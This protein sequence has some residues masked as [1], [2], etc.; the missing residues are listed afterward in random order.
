MQWF[1][2]QWYKSIETWNKAWM[3]LMDV[4]S[5]IVV[6]LL[7]ATGTL[8]C[9]LFLFIPFLIGTLIRVCKWSYKYILE[10]LYFLILCIVGGFTGL[11]LGECLTRYLFK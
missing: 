2:N 10:G 1:I 9:A 11:V 8:V 5:T 4:L 7:M 6:A 3:K